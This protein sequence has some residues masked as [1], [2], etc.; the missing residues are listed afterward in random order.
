M[1]KIWNYLRAHVGED[2]NPGHYITIFTALGIC[3]YLNYTLRFHRDFLS[4]QEGFV[5]LVR[6]WLFYA[7]PY[8]FT[9]F[10]YAF[11]YKR[12]HFLK[13]MKFWIKSGLVLACLAADSSLPFFRDWINESFASEI[14]FWA[15][16]VL[17]NLVSIFTVLLPLLLYYYLTK[18]K[19]T[20][21]YGLQPKQ[22]D[23]KPYITMLLLM[24]PL[25][26]AA[27]F[28]ASFLRQYP[29]YKV[30][31]AHAYLGIPEWLTVAAYELAYGFDFVSVEFLFRG[32]MVIGMMTFFGRGTVLAMASVY[33]FLH[34]GKPAGEAISS[35]FGGYVLGII[36]YETKS[37]WGGIIVHVGIA[38]MMESIAYLQKI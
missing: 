36:A 37:I 1:K 18:E 16:K 24:L 8:F 2:L 30:T 12:T 28:H 4:Q 32:F 31:D 13:E 25:M 20:R 38:W 7:T 6:Y 5:K 11:F 9:V 17:N 19:D 22:F 35:I 34:F 21:V 14:Q 15:Y 33:C 3:I 23:K 26:L 10:S 29:M 27:S